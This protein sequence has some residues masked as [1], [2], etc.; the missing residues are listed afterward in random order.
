MRF[1]IK[2]TGQTDPSDALI[3]IEA[4]SFAIGPKSEHLDVC[5]G[6]DFDLTIR[7]AGSDRLKIK[8]KGGGFFVAG[9]AFK[10][11]VLDI[12]DAFQVGFYTLH[13][14]RGTLPS[15][16]C[17]EVTQNEITPACERS[18][19]NFTQAGL[20][21]RFWSYLLFFL[22]LLGTFLLPFL[23]T[24]D[25]APYSGLAVPSLVPT[26]SSWSAGPLHSAHVT[27]GIDNNCTACHSE[28]FDV[29]P[30]TA[31]LACH[32]Q[33]NEHAV[34]TAANKT[35]FAGMACTDCHIEHMEP[36]H[37]VNNN[38]KVCVDCH[39]ALLSW[40]PDMPVAG[41]FSALDHP[42]FKVS[43]WQYR[44]EA[45]NNAMWQL[46]KRLDA[47]DQPAVEQSN[48]K[49]PHDT[50]MDASKMQA[51]NNGSGL[52]CV[53]CHQIGA[54][55]GEVSVI[56]MEKNC[57][58]CHAL[59]YDL[60]DP[61][62]VLPHGS[63]RQAIAEMESHFY[64]KARELS[65][66]DA[67]ERLYSEAAHQFSDSGCVTCHW[68]EENPAMPLQERWRVAPVRISQDWYPAASFNHAAHMNTPGISSESS[69]CLSCHGADKSHDARDILMPKKE[70]C[71]GCH[72]SERGGSADACISCHVFHPAKGSPSLEVRGHWLERA[73]LDVDVAQ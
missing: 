66:F 43:L 10:S 6:L 39:G 55:D 71:L 20:R 47:P 40:A 18:A 27:A 11:R 70:T 52:A 25:A 1:L 50:H 49:F 56:S 9:R 31:C 17:I 7:R 69:S 65:F 30:D 26:A 34:I 57:Q 67:R 51:D 15:D 73:E 54:V 8:S 32:D 72:N 28:V 48:L 53:D 38:P 41:R 14:T 63:E 23:D 62:R 64:R 37:L 61:E 22:M 4:Q 68:V 36:S 21:I 59:T 13:I 3:E 2:K 44:P 45:E 12:G 29:I 16:L 58:S 24:L 5:P 46:V 19:M 42:E 60:D 33:L 35:H